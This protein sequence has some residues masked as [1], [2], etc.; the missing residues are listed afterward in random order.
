MGSPA[1]GLCSHTLTANKKKILSVSE[2]RQVCPLH[3]RQTESLTPHA[4][5]LFNRL[6][7]FSRKEQ[8]LPALVV[9]LSRPLLCP[10]SRA[11]FVHGCSHTERVEQEE[12]SRAAGLCLL[13]LWL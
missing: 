12:L 2:V 7:R 6:K 5:R 1:D 3:C 11:D 9:G 8:L 13:P 10:D 4:V